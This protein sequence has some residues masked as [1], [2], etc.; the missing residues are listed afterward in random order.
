MPDSP[1]QPPRPKQLTDVRPP[2]ALPG[3]G[4]LAP[5]LTRKKKTR[6][7]EI[8]PEL[9]K[10]EKPQRVMRPELK[11]ASM[12]L[13]ALVVT[14]ILGGVIMRFGSLGER[15]AEAVAA[16][17]KM[18]SE[19]LPFVQ[20]LSTDS[21][22]GIST[23][24]GIGSSSFSSIAKK[25]SL[26][27]IWTF[28]VQ[29]GQALDQ[30]QKTFISYQQL[31][32]EISDFLNTTPGIFLAAQPGPLPALQNIQTQLEAL[33][34][35]NAKLATSLSAVKDAL[36]LDFS[37]YVALGAQLNRLSDVFN[38]GIGWLEEPRR[39]IIAFQ[40]SSEMRPSGGFFGS[41][42]DLTIRNGVIEDIQVHD[43]TD[44][45]SEFSESIIPPQPLQYI[46]KNWRAADSNWFFNFPDSASQMLSFLEKSDLYKPSSTTFDAIITVS[47]RVFQDILT[48]T[49]PI[50]LKE[51]E[52]TLTSK[53]FLP[54][55]QG[56][57]VEGRKKAAED[58]KGILSDIV[59]VLQDRMMKLP[60]G[61]RTELSHLL[62]DWIQYKDIQMFGRDESFQSIV[63]FLGADGSVASS[64]HTQNDDYL[65]IID[66]T[67]GGEKTNYVMSRSIVLRAQINEDGRVSH[68]LT[69][70]RK[71]S[72]NKD[73]ERWYRVTNRTYQRVL[74]PEGSQ[75]LGSSG[76][77][78]RNDPTRSYSSSYL[79]DP[80]VTTL[81]QTIQEAL[82]MPAID[83]Y[84]ESGKLG[85]AG[86]V[87][88]EAGKQTKSVLDYEY[89]LPEQVE[90]GTRYTFVFDKQS[91]TQGSYDF[92]ISAPVGYRFKE[93]KLPIFEYRSEDIPGR[94]TIDLTLEKI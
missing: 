66:S 37:E 38:S 31:M 4:S 40:N 84:K 30:F 70:V 53:N 79:K 46:T 45:D 18:S 14:L 67:I 63:R 19:Q 26:S 75:V 61:Q 77:T 89:R 1:S 44:A 57:V 93:N 17:R 55:I 33:K 9:Q 52:I 86:W 73:D 54:I 85:V 71:H 13:G 69:V 43:I 59:R 11:K 2:E 42:A 28:F 47:P 24:S 83:L 82:G 90:S 94:V 6:P 88:T 56:D 39:V 16:A 25:A 58:P 72:G 21:S 23:T 50:E 80:L 60:E 68:R 91:G 64:A 32:G 41:Y 27:D 51:R 49:G 22:F 12:L 35:Q 7:E 87:F 3:E 76:F 48:I 65:A 81:E 29:G 34:M 20:A 8:L 15:A 5:L 62:T 74:I 78:D 36:P 10:A 92:E